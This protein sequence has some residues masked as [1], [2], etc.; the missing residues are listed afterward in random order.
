MCA[1][2]MT[3]CFS[4]SFSSRRICKMSSI[5]SPGSI[6]MASCVCSSPSTEQLHCSG[7]TGNT[8]WII[9]KT[10]VEVMTLPGQIHGYAHQIKEPPKRRLGTGTF[11]NLLPRRWLRGGAGGFY[12]LHERV[13]SGTL[14]AG[15]ERK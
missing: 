14:A 11:D 7:P 4:E 3:I 12:T 1:C 13:G 5:W 2:V 10:I 9:D 6:T 8:L 15:E